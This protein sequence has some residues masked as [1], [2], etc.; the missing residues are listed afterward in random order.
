MALHQLGRDDEALVHLDRS[1]R[2]LEKGLGAGHAEL[3]DQLSNRGEILNAVGR[4]GDARRSFER[5]QA[6]WERE[7]GGDDLNLS[8]ALTGVGNSF[9]PKEAR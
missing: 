2:L 7:L 1:I 6:I 9:W 4:F 3:A 8:F 5:A